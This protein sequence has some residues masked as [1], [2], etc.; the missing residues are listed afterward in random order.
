MIKFDLIESRYDFFLIWGHGLQH[1]DKIID[2]IAKEQNFEIVNIVKHKTK[3]IKKFVAKVYEH[4]YV[5]Y[6]HLKNKTKYL[7]TTPKKVMCIFIRNKNPDEVWKLGHGTG[8]I[9]SNIIK[10]Y[11][12]IIR[13]KFNKK[14]EDRLTENHVIHASDNELQVHHLLKYLGYEEG[15]CRFDKHKNK[16]FEVPHFI[17]KFSEYIIHEVNVSDLVCN[18]IIKDNIQRISIEDSPQY[19]FLIGYKDEYKMY[20]NQHQ[21]T[22][23]KA[24]YDLGKYQ[25]MSE[26]FEYLSNGYHTNFVIVKKIEDRF[27]VLDGLHRASIVKYQGKEKIVIAEIIK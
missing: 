2:L 21:G 19:K 12:N 20:I 27:M 14:K 23:L 13:E 10:K 6:S 3:N 8:H 22:R 4:D 25:K 9:E 15:V 17:E 16:P 7:M 24:Y 18:T 11:K 1:K 5:P 26:N